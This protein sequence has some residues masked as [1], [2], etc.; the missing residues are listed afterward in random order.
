MEEALVKVLKTFATSLV[1][2]EDKMMTASEA[3]ES[4]LRIAELVL[5]ENGK[6]ELINHIEQ[7]WN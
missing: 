2:A 1:C 3:V 6:Q 7:L 5:S 4:F